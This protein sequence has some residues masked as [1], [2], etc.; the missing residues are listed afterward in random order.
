MSK[1]DDG[2]PAF[3]ALKTSLMRDHRREPERFTHDY[4]SEGGMSLR[5]YAAIHIAAAMN[6][7]PDLLKIVTSGQI[8]DGSYAYRM[9]ATAYEWADAM[10]VARKASEG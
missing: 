6:A 7:N 10:L 8:H 2:G 4:A 1:I 5:D 3:P 9:A